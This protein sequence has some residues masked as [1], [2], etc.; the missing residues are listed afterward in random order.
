MDE[1]LARELHASLNPDLE[2]DERLARQIA[3]EDKAKGRRGKKR[4]NKRAEEPPKE[5][6]VQ[7]CAITNN[8]NN[9]MT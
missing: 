5:K 3:S 1:R 2:E 4:T 6:G 8:D 9:A 7:V